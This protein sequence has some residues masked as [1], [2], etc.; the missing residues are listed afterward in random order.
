MDLESDD[1]LI[2]AQTFCAF[3]KTTDGVQGETDEGN[4]P[5]PWAGKGKPDWAG[6]DDAESSNEDA[7]GPPPWAGKPGGPKNADS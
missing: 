3:N 5:P 7:G 6:N 2:E 4:D 1:L